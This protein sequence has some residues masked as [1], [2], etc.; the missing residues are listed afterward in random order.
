MSDFIADTLEAFERPWSAV[1]FVVGNNC[2]V[3]QYLRDRGAI[4]FIG[5]A[6]RRFNLAVQ[7]YL[8]DHKELIAKTNDLMMKLA[9]SKGED[10]LVKLRK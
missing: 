4:P 6:S 8:E 3:N 10:V 5:C 2:S 7:L 9:L 1:L